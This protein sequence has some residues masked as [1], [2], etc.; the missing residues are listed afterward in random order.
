MRDA[1][2]LAR[3]DSKLDVGWISSALRGLPM[4]NRLR[5]RVALRATRGVSAVQ[6]AKLPGFQLLR[7]QKFG[8][9]ANVKLWRYPSTRDTGC[10]VLLCC[11]PHGSHSGVS[12]QDG[13]QVLADRF[14]CRC[15]ALAIGGDPELVLFV[16]QP[17][18]FGWDSA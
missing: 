10:P 5:D 8:V 12:H 1:V 9:S 7:Y 16:P 14:L 3:P 2:P 13:V 11:V 18:E 15:R 17:G 4:L 6:V